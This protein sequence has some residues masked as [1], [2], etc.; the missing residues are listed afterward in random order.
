MLPSLLLRQVRLCRSNLGSSVSFCHWHQQQ[1]VRS[2]SAT[3]N[4]NDDTSNTPSPNLANTVFSKR[5]G[6]RTKQTRSRQQWTKE[7]DELLEQLYKEHA[8]R[9]THIA[10][11]L[12]HRA[13]ATIYNR[14]Q[15]LFQRT[16]TRHGRWT[17]E[18]L[19]A[20]RH[21]TAKA[22]DWHTIQ[23]QLPYPRTL[24]SIK[25]TWYHTLNPQWTRG[26]WTKED[27]SKL[28]QLVEQFGTDDWCLISEHMRTRS[29]RQCLEK[30]RYQIEPG[31]KGQY[32]P[33]ESAAIKA[34][35]D[36]Y[37]SRDFKVIKK[38]INSQRTSRQISQHYRYALDPNFDRSPWTTQEKLEV[39]RLVQTLGKDMVKV[40][41]AMKSR[42]QIRDMWNQYNNVK[43]WS[44][45]KRRSTTS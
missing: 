10:T 9:Y 23:Q 39:Y 32:T 6:T 19:E 4:T 11:L 29:P 18:E 20:L 40:K 26:R 28:E 17:E 13:V 33:E 16:T 36:K 22:T 41:E 1:L 31:H 21:L 8:P 24:F 45:K 12:P 43:A 42:R 30:Y 15:A 7:E 3:A 25:Q 5:Y 35:V 14:C 27:T 34:A 44:D 37:G 38:A 2:Y